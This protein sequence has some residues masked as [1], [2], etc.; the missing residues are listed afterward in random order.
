[1]PT[2]NRTT[3]H[4]R[5]PLW[6]RLGE[7]AALDYRTRPGLI[8]IALERRLV[9]LEQD[10]RNQ[11]PLPEPPGL[12]K[13]WMPRSQEPV[14]ATEQVARHVRFPPELLR[15]VDRQC[16][17]HNESRSRFIITACEEELAR[18]HLARQANLPPPDRALPPQP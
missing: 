12:S 3:F 5:D 11:K 18:I 14:G 8:L 16:Q 7:L 17:R 4:M 2:D 9:K 10:E 13:H 6:H 15:R 1:M